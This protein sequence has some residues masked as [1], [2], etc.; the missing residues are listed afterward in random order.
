LFIGSP[1]ASDKPLII[2][3]I[4]NV[5]HVPKIKFKLIDMIQLGTCNI[6]IILHYIFPDGT[7]GN[8]CNKCGFRIGQTWVFC[9]S[10]R[11]CMKVAKRVRRKSLHV[12]CMNLSP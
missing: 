9:V 7:K 5:F 10:S 11:Q 2:L 1:S 8:T 12:V 3:S 4:D 6:N